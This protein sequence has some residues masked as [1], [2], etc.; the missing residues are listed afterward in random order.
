[1]K[2]WLPTYIKC[3]YWCCTG[4]QSR[5]KVVLEEPKD[6]LVVLILL[7]YHGVV[8]VYH[9]CICFFPSA[10][11]LLSSGSQKINTWVFIKVL[12]CWQIVGLIICTSHT[13]KASAVGASLV[14]FS[15]RCRKNS[16]MLPLKMCV[17]PEPAVFRQWCY[18]GR[19]W[20]A[21]F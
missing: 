2:Y 7:V 19:R 6:S 15:H 13:F 16:K 14:L 11:Y 3:W 5:T 4:T 17:A 12:M 8:Q 10:S 1:M 9:H 21:E 20:A 18:S